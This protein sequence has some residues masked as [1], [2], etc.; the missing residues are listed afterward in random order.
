MGRVK[1]KFPAEN[2]LFLATIPVRITDINYGGH[3]GNDA[4]LSIMHEARMMMLAANGWTELNAGGNSLI[5]S[6]VEIAYKGESF[7][8]DVLYISLFATELQAS[9]FDLLYHIATNR[10]GR[11]LDI[12]HGRTGMVCFNYDTRRIVPMTQELHD[13][14]VGKG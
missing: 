6:D 3:T 14:L 12:A 5:M 11:E 4:I 1:L 10:D 2:P 13:M 9:S 7:Y 8:G